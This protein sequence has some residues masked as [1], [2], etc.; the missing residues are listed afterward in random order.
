M[1]RSLLLLFA[2]PVFAGCSVDEDTIQRLEKRQDAQIQLL[3]EQNNL[4][5]EHSALLARQIEAQQQLVEMLADID[6]TLKENHE[7]AMARART[8]VE[9][10]DAQQPEPAVMSA[11]QLNAEGKAVLGRNEWV[12]FE[13]LGRNL[14]ARVD[15]G[16]L[17]SSLNATDLRPFERDGQSWIRFRV[18]DEEHPDG[19]EIYEAPLLR[20]VRIR[21]A[22]SEELDRRPVIKLKVRVGEL[23]GDTEFTLTSRE[24]MLYPALLGRNFLRDV[25]IVDVARKFVQKKYAPESKADGAE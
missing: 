18:P 16:A 21:Q 19:G 7:Q 5:E 4:I 8:Q 17:S 15:T 10:D 22:S 13:L 20:Y 12:W 1:N 11:L 6:R 14:K 3:A 25:A 2:A 23:S 9:E 24:D